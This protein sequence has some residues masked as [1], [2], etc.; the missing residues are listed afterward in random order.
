MVGERAHGIPRRYHD[1]LAG[2]ADAGRTGRCA[3]T[4]VAAWIADAIRGVTERRRTIGLAKAIRRADAALVAGSTASDVLPDLN[5]SLANVG[6]ATT[7]FADPVP[8]TK[9]A[10]NPDADWIIGGFLARG[11]AT[12][13]TGL[14]KSGKTTLLTEWLRGFCG[15]SLPGFRVTPA[16]AL[17]ITEESASLWVH[18]RRERELTDQIHVLV[19][20]FRGRPDPATWAAFM[21]HIAAAVER[22]KYDVLILDTWAGLAP[23][24]SENDAAQVLSALAPLIQMNEQIATLLVHHPAKGDADEGRSPRGS[25]ALAGAVDILT[26]LRRFRPSDV[27]DTCRTLTSYSRFGDTP[28]KIVVEWE[29][30]G[31]HFREGLQ[32]RDV[33]RGERQDHITEI[34]RDGPDEGLGRVEIKDLWSDGDAPGDRTL[35]DDL[36]DGVKTGRWSR[37]GAAKAT[38][39]RRMGR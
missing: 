1:R 32:V 24:E 37:C 21:R 3:P 10:G 19:R 20:P 26:E 8:I 25:G 39:Y 23:M 6:P 27:N 2:A 30:D 16:R 35:K 11:A 9:L 14:W 34:I 31:Y 5:D 13:L 15:Q 17:V 4:V 7:A 22:E 38:K 33:V 18:R 12:L 28:A 36:A 29:R